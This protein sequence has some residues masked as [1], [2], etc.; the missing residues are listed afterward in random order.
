MKTKRFAIH[1]DTD[2]AVKLK[3]IYDYLAQLPS[4]EWEV[5]VRKPVRTSKQNRAM[6]MFC[7]WIAEALNENDLY[8]SKIYKMD[9]ELTWTPVMVKEML[10]KPVQEVLTKK[11]SSTRLTTK[12]LTEVA[13]LLQ[14]NLA[15]KGLSISFPSIEGM[16]NGYKKYEINR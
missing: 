11:K 12:E 9:A 2:R 14:K 15:L 4:T 16:I 5:V 3:E 7:G 13:D 1:K 10:W 6:H 8:F